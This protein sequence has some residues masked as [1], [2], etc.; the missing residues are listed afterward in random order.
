MCVCVG[1][2]GLDGRWSVLA[3]AARIRCVYAAAGEAGCAVLTSQA[4][5]LLLY[6]P[7]YMGCCDVAFGR[8]AVKS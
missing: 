6:I 4:A 2:G 5:T 1:G 8:C 3:R 7:T